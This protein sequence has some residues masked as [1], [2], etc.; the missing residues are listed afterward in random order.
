MARAGPCTCDGGV[1]RASLQAGSVSRFPCRPSGKNQSA[2]ASSR[3]MSCMLSAVAVALRGCTGGFFS[4]GG[5]E[6]MAG[7]MVVFV[8]NLHDYLCII[9]YG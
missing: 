1:S 5:V 3:C 8:F 4:G 7:R 9:S 2:V 6:M